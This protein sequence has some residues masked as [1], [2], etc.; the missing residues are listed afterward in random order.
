MRV[1]N[2]T[3]YSEKKEKRYITDRLLETAF[4]W[5]AIGFLW[6]S[7][8]DIV[9]E[10][11]PEFLTIVPI[12][13][14]S[15]V[16]EKEQFVNPMSYVPPIEETTESENHLE[17]SSLEESK[18]WEY[19]KQG[20]LDIL[21][22]PKHL[23]EGF[24][25]IA[26]VYIRDWNAY[27]GTNYVVFDA[28]GN[29]MPQTFLLMAVV[30]WLVVVAN[31]HLLRKR[32]F[33]AF[34]PLLVMIM[35]FLVG[36]SPKENGVIYLF[37]G[38]IMLLSIEKKD[39][40]HIFV[41]KMGQ[42][43]QK[44]V[45][46]VKV[47]AFVLPMVSLYF[48][49]NV[50]QKPISEWQTKKQDILEW[51]A[52]FNIP[53]LIE[54][55]FRGWDFQLSNE[56]L[57]NRTPQYTGKLILGVDAEYTPEVNLY[58]KGFYGTTYKGGTWSKDDSIFS[59]ACAKSGYE[60]TEM[61]QF[62]SRMPFQIMEKSEVNMKNE[63]V[64]SYKKSFGNTA[65]VPYLF[66]YKTFDEEYTFSGD[67]LLEKSLTDTSVHV[68]G[69]MRGNMTSVIWSMF[70][71][72]GTDSIEKRKWYNQ[73][74][75]E[76]TNVPSNMEEIAQ[77]A[78]I[79]KKRVKTAFENTGSVKLFAPQNLNGLTKL[80]EAEIEQAMGENLYRQSLASFTAN[81]LSEIMS[82]NLELEDLPFGKDP[83][84]FAMTESQ[85]GYCMHFA[86]AA[87]LILRELGVPARYASGYVVRP[88]DFEWVEE[89]KNYHADILDYHSHAWVEIY[90][91]YMG[92]V[93]FEVTPGYDSSEG[94]LPTQQQQNQQ[95]SE[96]GQSH[97]ETQQTE[98]EDIQNNSELEDITENTQDTQAEN[99]SQELENSEHENQISGNEDF[100]G[101]NGMILGLQKWFSDMF[102]KA[103]EFIAKNKSM[104]LWGIVLFSWMILCVFA[105]KYLYEYYVNML[106]EEIRKKQ[107]KKAVVR[108]NR[109]IYGY[110]WLRFWKKNKNM[111]VLYKKLRDKTLCDTEYGMLL[112]ETFSNVS[113]EDWKKYMEIVKKMYYS[114]QEITEEE[115]W[116]CYKCYNNLLYLEKY[117]R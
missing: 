23:Q 88:A 33:Y 12:E 71:L 11:Y 89:T 53:T 61:A 107:T 117:L 1:K 31:A 101:K 91:D 106:D 67:Y 98:T 81:Y 27:Y 10:G 3:F 51:Q 79:I 14:D 109:R 59:K 22:N 2:W 38:T 112:E 96:N 9:K 47:M 99:N 84:V 93:P 104:V 26:D 66:D 100:N 83:I 8:F 49:G 78:E 42:N 103:K 95:E 74:A 4:L 21:K 116:H 43:W 57:N 13:Q 111:R 63:Y 46:F 37:I 85:E 40:V 20:C 65:Y 55:F 58:L 86:S 73:V 82:Y 90:L 7:F 94:M 15:D 105:G 102:A 114:K 108:I 77:A 56:N 54:D 44:E 16:V 35:Q 30:G 52:N 19:F 39:S 97:V 28:T 70:E 50:F 87:T 69:F 32:V 24:L 113:K 17:D 92:W 80:Q 115:M 72:S 18:K 68:T 64:I 48:A 5:I 76:Y 25:S 34:F 41:E 29:Y 60:E 110:V 62:I 6:L 36:T 75:S 45:V